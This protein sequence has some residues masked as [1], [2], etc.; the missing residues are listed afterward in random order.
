MG[1]IVEFLDRDALADVLGRPAG[2]AFFERSCQGADI[3][4]GRACHRT[5]S[6]PAELRRLNFFR[7]EAMPPIALDAMGGD[8]APVA[9]VEGARRARDE[10][11]I[12]VVLVGDPDL[13]GEVSSDR[14]PIPV[15]AASQ[16][17]GFSDDPARAGV[18]NLLGIYRAVTGKSETAV[19]ADF[20]SRKQAGDD[21]TTLSYAEVVDDQFRF[22]KA[23]PT[24]AV[25][26]NC[27]G[28]ELKPAVSEKL[29][30]LYPADRA[31]G[32]REG[33]IRGAFVVTKDLSD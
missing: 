1:F 17:I 5:P 20:E 21:V 18:Q 7:P 4:D 10:H 29:S 15:H 12:E 8:H 25:C 2:E 16:V 13:L 19:L 26:L 14:G 6:D 32:F 33:D 31:T 22:M 30:A 9:I 11:G 24:A 23:I 27:H 28:S 3:V